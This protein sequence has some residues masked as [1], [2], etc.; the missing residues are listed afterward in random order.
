MNG[1]FLLNTGS[2]RLRARTDDTEVKK[3]CS[4]VMLKT[5]IEEAA[6]EEG[7][8]NQNFNCKSQVLEKEEK[9]FL[10]SKVSLKTL[11]T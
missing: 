4:A 8:G 3:H 6:A 1:P 7:F 11:R 10:N 2:H 9:D 5:A